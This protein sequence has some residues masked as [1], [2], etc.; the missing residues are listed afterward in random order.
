MSLFIT[1]VD[2]D[3]SDHTQALLALLDEYARHPNGGG[4]A[5]SAE[6]CHNL[7]PALQRRQDYLGL[8]AFD[9]NQAVGLLNAFEGFSSFKAKPLLNIHD[10]V[11]TA[12]HRN[13]GIGQLLLKH[14][15]QIAIQRGYCKLTLEV[16]ANNRQAR[17]AYRKF[18][19]QGYELDP[20][21]GR[22]EFWEKPCGRRTGD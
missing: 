17:Q 15:E 19:F 4:K 1:R 10:I 6:T 14:A 9:A 11:V 2:L 13:R 21:L 7:I 20:R 22:A 8:I 3:L 12:S 5:L 18:G 16:L